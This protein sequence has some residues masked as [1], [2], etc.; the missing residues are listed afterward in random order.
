MPATHDRQ[1]AID[2][3]NKGY[4]TLENKYGYL[5]ESNATNGCLKA[6]YKCNSC[7]GSIFVTVFLLF[8]LLIFWCLLILI[9]FIV[10]LILF[11]YFKYSFSDYI[12]LFIGNFRLFL[13]KFKKKETIVYHL[14]NRIVGFIQLVEFMIQFKSNTYIESMKKYERLF[15]GEAYP[16]LF[17]LVT[18]DYNTIYKLIHRQNS[19]ELVTDRGKTFVG[20]ELSKDIIN[21]GIA[22]VFSISDHRHNIMRD[23]NFIC[24][25]VNYK[26]ANNECQNMDKYAKNKFK[27][28]PAN[29]LKRYFV[30][31]QCVKYYKLLNHAVLF[32]RIFEIEFTD[33]EL[34]WFDTD[35]SII[36]TI[37]MPNWF[38]FLLFNNFMLRKIYKFIHKLTEIVRARC[39]NDTLKKLQNYAYD[40]DLNEHAVL[41][42]AILMFCLGGGTKL[43]E[44]VIKRFELNPQIEYNYFCK[45]KNKYILELCRLHA[46]IAPIQSNIA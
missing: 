1:Q 30:Y 39:K 18:N 5:I 20:F 33:K 41:H 27:K 16:Y 17:C 42:S 9:L 21:Y 46:M 19:N 13:L 25:H 32:W 40:N 3:I 45:N 15:G 37:P 35:L 8:P 43:I 4:Q 29:Y 11:K 7:L 22:H 6:C 14:L 31:P 26:N 24:L 44:N 23:I 36:G 10:Y 12:T 2:L 34:E 38:H 28:V